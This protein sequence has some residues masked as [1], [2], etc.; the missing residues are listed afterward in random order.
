MYDLPIGKGAFLSL[1]AE[2][3]YDIVKQTAEYSFGCYFN[4]PLALILKK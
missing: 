2:P 1:R 4:V 3:Y